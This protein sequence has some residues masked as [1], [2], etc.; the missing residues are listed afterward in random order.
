MTIEAI[1]DELARRTEYIQRLEACV[2]AADMMAA[3]P[4]R[5]NLDA[6]IEAANQLSM[7]KTTRSTLRLACTIADEGSKT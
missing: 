4:T 6:Y 7:P 1:R 2:R 5:A 3:H